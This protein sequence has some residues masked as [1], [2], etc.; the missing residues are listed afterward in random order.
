MLLLNAPTEILLREQV[1]G[2][3]Q[4][5]PSTLWHILSYQ[6]TCYFMLM[7][8]ISMIPFVLW[9]GKMIKVPTD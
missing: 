1:T 8:P 3:L 7:N 2:F 6:G 9:D 4:F 5:L